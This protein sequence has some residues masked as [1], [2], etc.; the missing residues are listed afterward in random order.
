MKLTTKSEYSIL[1][2][3]YMARQSDKN[4]IKTR[5][6]KIIY[7]VYQYVTG[8]N[9][10]WEKISSVEGKR[11]ENRNREWILAQMSI[12]KRMATRRNSG[13][14]IAIEMGFLR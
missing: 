4:F 13:A 3:I 7:S 8:L 1:A 12:A 11:Y 2:L 6:I 10:I 5:L 14:P 9:L